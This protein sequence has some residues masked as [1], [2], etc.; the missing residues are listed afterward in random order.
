MWSPRGQQVMIATPAQPHRRYGIGAVDDH[1]GE[2]VVR[3]ERRKRRQEIAQLLEAL[4]AKYP[5]G[6]IY[7]A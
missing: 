1:T 7:V 4:L 3:F 2:A 6:T 5:T